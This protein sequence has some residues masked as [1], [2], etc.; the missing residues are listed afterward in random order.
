VA[1]TT[2]AGAGAGA[3]I[4]IMMI[5]IVPLEGRRRCRR[6]IHSFSSSAASTAVASQAHSRVHL[7]LHDNTNVARTR[8]SSIERQDKMMI[9]GACG[10]YYKSYSTSR[11]WRFI[12]IFE[13]LYMNIARAHATYILSS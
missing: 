9:T 12:I 13:I 2:G 1:T 6:R 5:V 7:L 3:S 8:N 4:I 10:K 11:N